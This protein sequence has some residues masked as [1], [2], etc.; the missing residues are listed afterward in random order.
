MI[1]KTK[2]GAKSKKTD[3]DV[4]TKKF[5]VFSLLNILNILI[6]YFIL[7]SLDLFYCG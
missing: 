2:H 6:P 1:P 5:A 7:I 3:E 4:T